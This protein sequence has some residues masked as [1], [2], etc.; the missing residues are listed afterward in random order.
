MEGS[1]EGRKGGWKEKKEGKEGGNKIGK[2]TK[3]LLWKSSEAQKC[4][5]IEV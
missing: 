5:F 1:Q 2:L 3:F 4:L